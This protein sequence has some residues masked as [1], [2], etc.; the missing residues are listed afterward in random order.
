MVPKPGVPGFTQVSVT[1]FFYVD[2][3]KLD[4][5]PYTRVI[6]AGQL[7]LVL[8]NATVSCLLLQVAVCC[9]IF[10]G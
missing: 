7:I 3:Y 5:W 9:S 10:V 2:H 4:C 8:V 1:W 6:F